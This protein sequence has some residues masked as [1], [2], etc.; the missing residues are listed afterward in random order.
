MIMIDYY[1]FD[2]PVYSCTEGRYNADMDKGVAKR[3]KE[4]NEIFDMSGTSRTK[5]PKSDVMAKVHFRQN[6]GG[7]WHFNQ[8]V[9]WLRLYVKP[10]HV[11]DHLWWV[12]AIQINRIMRKKR[13]YLMTASNVLA[14]YFT[15]DDDSEIIYQK[16]LADI[17]RLA[18]ENPLRGRYVDLE[19]FRNI[20]PFI[21][22]RA[23]L[24]KL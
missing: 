24:D 6:F 3:L 11:G 13:F 12:D 17:E 16:T 18:S 14:T 9:G 2:I 10:S 23:L 8:I 7:P 5:A 22:W 15:P 4:L 19:N 21:N 1:I 20:G